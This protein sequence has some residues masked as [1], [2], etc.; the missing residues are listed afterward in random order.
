[1]ALIGRTI[2][3][4]FNTYHPKTGVATVADSTPS[5]SVYKND[6]G[7]P[8]SL[9]GNSIAVR[10]GTTSNYVITLPLT[11]GNGFTHGDTFILK[12]SVTVAGITKIVTLLTFIATTYEADS[13]VQGSDNKVLLSNN[14]H[15]GATIPTVT[16]VTNDVG[17]T[18]AGADKA[19]ST[20]TRVLTAGTNIALAKG[21]GVTGFNDIS[22]TDVATAVWNAATAT[23]G[24]AGSYG[25]LVE[26]NLDAAV[27]SITVPTTGAIADAV[28]NEAIADHL[29]AGSTGL[30]LNSASSAGDPWSTAVPGAY[31]AGT[32]GYILGTNLN[33]T[34]SSRSTHSAADVWSVATRVLTAG[35]NIALAKGT[36]VTGFND[37]STTDVATAVWNAATATYG[38]AGSYGLLVETNL[39]AAVSSITVPTT[40]AIAD[41]VWNEAIADHLG[42]GSTG[43]ALNSASSAGD[44]WSTAVP[45]AYGAGT[46]GYILG[47]NLNTTVSSRS[48]HSAADVWSVATRVLTAGTNIALAKGTGVT[49]FNDVSTTDV[50]TAVWNAATATYGTAGSYGLL[51]E[52]NLD[53]AVSSKASQASV[54]DIPINPLLTNDSRLNNLDTTIGS[55]LASAS[56]IAPDNSSITAI[57]LKTDNIQWGDITD[58]K[59][60]ALGKWV[61]DPDLNTLT[62]YRQDGVTILKTFS[63]TSTTQIVPAYI[64]RT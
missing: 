58:I 56:Y 8:L 7:T 51:V 57:K 24:T 38:T 20:A 34:V 17:I 35:T 39:D 44:P 47:T 15:T 4:D 49:G 59:D 45:G 64:Q 21:T 28:W 37:I 2:Y 36:G 1:M 10:S 27:S 22:T 48:T 29:G 46:A 9:S 23:Y 40:G 55:R 30:A 63:L 62:L 11:V 42:A 31:G 6:S 60:E 3:P 16:T 12:V 61:L 43:L 13:I 52:T 19:W 41:A 14:A 18:Q 54:N 5:Y 53:A 50:A 26:T 33:T 32:A 25:L